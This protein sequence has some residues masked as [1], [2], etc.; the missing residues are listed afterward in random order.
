[1][2][3]MALSITTPWSRLLLIL[4]APLLLL[5]LMP[6][7]TCDMVHR[8]SLRRETASLLEL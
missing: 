2:L 4:A 8:L 6:T 5:L 1:M 7:H 3:C